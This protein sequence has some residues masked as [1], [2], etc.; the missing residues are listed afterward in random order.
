MLFYCQHHYGNY[1][2]FMIAMLYSDRIQMF[3][4]LSLISLCYIIVIYLDLSMHTKL[5][6]FICVAKSGCVMMYE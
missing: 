1:Q 3:V 2:H 6:Y 5:N 4:Y